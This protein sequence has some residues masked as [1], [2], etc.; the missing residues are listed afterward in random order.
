MGDKPEA[1]HIELEKQ[2]SVYPYADQLRQ[3]YPA[4]AN[5]SEEEY[6]QIERRLVRRIDMRLMPM[7]ILIYLLN[8]IDRNAIASAKYA[9]WFIYLANVRLAGI[10]EDLNLHGNAYQTAVSIL[11]VGYITMQ[12]PSNLLLDRIG[13]PSLYLP[14]CMICWGIISTCTAAVQNAGGLYAARLLLGIVEAAY[15]PGCLFYLSSWYCKKEL[16]LRTAVLFSGSLL[17]GAISGLI[18]AGIRYGM[19]GLHGLRAWRWL[20]IIEGS[21]TIG[22]AVFAIFILPDFPVTT[23]W[24]TDQ[25]RELAMYRLE[26]EAGVADEH[27]RDIKLGVKLALKDPKAYV[28]TLMLIGYVS[29]AGITNFFPTVVATLG[30]SDVVSLLLTVPPYAFACITALANARH[31]DKVQ[32]R[33]MHALC[34]IFV[35]LVAFIIAATTT[36]FAPRYVAMMLL[37]PGCYTGY[38]IALSWISASLPRPPAKRAVALALA[39]AISNATSIYVSY[40]YPDSDGPQYKMAMIVNCCTLVLAAAMILLMRYM[41]QRENRKIEQAEIHQPGDGALLVERLQVEHGFRYLI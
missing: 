4:I 28:F 37:V 27:S 35:G 11:F 23:K 14:G 40:L 34:P 20:F 1:D 3:R 17:S 6:R 41:L 13:R 32:E 12:I 31:S 5:V 36:S 9:P 8:Y 2:E 29:S 21:I 19:D 30:K 7:V 10:V 26:L 33:S 18:S 24:L 38:V 25:E 15:F 39:N 16:S 22:V